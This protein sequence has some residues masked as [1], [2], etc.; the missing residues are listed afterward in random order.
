MVLLVNKAMRAEKRQ[1][2]CEGRLLRSRAS[3][4]GE[5]K[6]LLRLPAAPGWCL[7]GHLHGAAAG[8]PPVASKEVETSVF[9]SKQKFSWQC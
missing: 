4:G 7:R 2:G 6:P 9:F 5:E 1:E 3:S 8:E